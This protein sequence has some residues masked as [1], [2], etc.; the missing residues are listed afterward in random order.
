M[1]DLIERSFIAWLLAEEQARQDQYR[2]YREYYD[3]DHDT[4]ITERQRKYLQLKMGEEFRANLC[5]IV[6]DALAERLQVTGFRADGVQDTK[7]WE[8]WTASRMD[9]GQK[10]VHTG[11]SRDG[12]TYVMVEW[13]D[14]HKRPTF[15]P[16]L[17]LC[18]GDGVQV[19]YAD[20][21]RVPQW[22]TK[23]WPLKTAGKPGKQRRLNVY[24]PDRVQH[25]ISDS[26]EYEGNWRPYDAA[27]H[28]AEEPSIGADGQPMGLTVVHF[29]N[30]PV[31]YNYGASELRDVVPIQNALNKAII[32]LTAAADTTA[33]RIFWMIGD[34]PSALNVGP[35]QWVYTTRPPSGENGAA[36][37]YFPG[38]DL[39]NLIAVIDALTMKVAQISRTPIS[40]FQVSG[41]RPAEGTLKQ[42]ESG[43]V[44]K[45]RDRQVVW[46]NCYEDMMYIARRMWNTYGPGP[47]LD[48]T[49]QI[50]TV[51]ADCETRNEALLLQSLQVKKA[52]GIPTETLWSEM[53]YDAEAIAKMQGSDEYRDRKSMAAM[54]LAALQGAQEEKMTRGDEDEGEDDD[55]A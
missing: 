32:D 55:R 39:G 51:W 17:A 30:K 54:G 38:E 12:D 29:A 40:Y 21:R 7:F 9:A 43:L 31:G 13:D 1:P 37:G 42:E 50:N 11:A 45:A 2:A 15:T 49:V 10:V 6:V 48:E 36:M 16:Q 4:A 41:M 44:G 34:D 8:W 35:G 3:G 33:F 19:I 26:D 23:R 25:L 52:L 14:A 46:G 22:A 28:A 24:Y 20:D 5:P 53:G 27:G 47:Q 18:N